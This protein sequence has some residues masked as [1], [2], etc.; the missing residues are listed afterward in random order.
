M[1]WQAVAQQVVAWKMVA[2]AEYPDQ[3]FA[4]QD[5]LELQR[6]SMTVRMLSS[7]DRGS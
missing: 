3:V 4:H 5:Q 1:E 6:V 7:S 2:M